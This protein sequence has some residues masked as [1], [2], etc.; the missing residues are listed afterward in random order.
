MHFMKN[1]FEWLKSSA[2]AGHHA[3]VSK[4]P[5]P[6]ATTSIDRGTTAQLAEMLTGLNTWK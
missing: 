2:P 5:V 3:P 1:Q 6:P 4:L